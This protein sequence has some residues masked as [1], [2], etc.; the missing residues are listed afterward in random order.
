ML[1]L[2]TCLIFIIAKANR[3]EDARVEEQEKMLES[4]GKDF[5]F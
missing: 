1:Y 3:T 2:R 5:L 4:P